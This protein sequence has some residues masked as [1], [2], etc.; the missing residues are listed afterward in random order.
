LEVD[1]MR[2]DPHNLRLA[3]VAGLAAAC[4]A[5]AGPVAAST[6]MAEPGPFDAQYFPL[7]PGTEF[8]YDGVVI[9]SEG[10]HNHRVIFSV[11]DLVKVV[12]GLVTRVVWD[13]DIND[14]QLSEAELA[15]FAQ[16]SSSNVWTVGEYPEEFED[17]KFAGAPSTWISGVQG[18]QAGILVPGQ[19]AVGTDPFVQGRAPAID[20]FD[21][22]QVV[23]TQLSLCGPTGCYSD[24]VV[25]DE[26]S[27]L[28]PEDGHQQ[29][30][31]APGV[32]LVRITA[33]SGESQEVLELTSVRQLDNGGLG[34]ARAGALRLDR[35]A[36]VVAADVYQDT[37]HAYLP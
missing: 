9:D 6:T 35:R 1:L 11:T 14:G 2:R 32:G 25:I 13:R 15:L 34:R 27:P 8:V 33:N 5:A 37:P 21:V 19:P 10:T 16:D 12:D 17:G 20:F 18:A 36:Y 23:Q 28:A 3:V 4:L 7:Q 24:V 29:K 26:W 30:Y 31:Y 22:G